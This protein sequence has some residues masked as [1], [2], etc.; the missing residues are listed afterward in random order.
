MIC[1]HI[2]A[3]RP[4]LWD[5]AM[6]K[7][8]CEINNKRT[9]QA[10]GKG[11]VGSWRAGDKTFRNRCKKHWNRGKM[12]AGSDRGQKGGISAVSVRSIWTRCSS[13]H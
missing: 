8:G 2:W 3:P 12:L 1:T 10:V 6:E 7:R 13:S 4:Q 9:V 11:T 5:P